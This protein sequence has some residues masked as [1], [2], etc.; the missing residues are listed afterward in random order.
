M[1]LVTIVRVDLNII[2]SFLRYFR[3]CLARKYSQEANLKDCINRFWLKS[4]PGVRNNSNKKQCSKC[5]VE[6]DHFTVSCP[7]N[8]TI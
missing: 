5:G 2:I 4:D 6:N 3:S 7:Q 1:A 8:G